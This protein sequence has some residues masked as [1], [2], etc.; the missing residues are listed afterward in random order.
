M[1]RTMSFSITGRQFT[2]EPAKIDRKR[3]YG[4][5]EVKAF[6]DDGN[7]CTLVSTDASGTVIIPKDGIAMGLIGPDGR[8]VQRSQLKTI[9]LDGAQAVPVAS[10][11][12]RVNELSSKATP[13]E[14]LDC[15]ITSFYHLADA[16]PDLISA[17]GDDIYRFDYCYLDSYETSPAFL[18]TS[19]VGEKTE[20]FML[21]G[22]QNRFEFI[23]LDQL[24][25]PDEE[26]P[27]GDDDDDIDFSMF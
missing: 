1:A 16:D 12:N 2:V 18:L 22:V 14:L 17:I 21:I 27:E 20:L 13:E 19:T 15:S 9:R 5:S 11:Y 26:D 8:W 7:E 3:L 23:G 10:S 25:V 6:D 4:W 24:A